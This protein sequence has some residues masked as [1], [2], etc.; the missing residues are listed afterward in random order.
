M[1]NGRNQTYSSHTGPL[2]NLV[3]ID[4][5]QYTNHIAGCLMILAYNHRAVKER[6]VSSLVLIERMV[7]SLVLIE[8]MVS[9]LATIEIKKKL[10]NKPITINSQSNKAKKS[11]INDTKQG[12]QINLE[13]FCTTSPFINYWYCVFLR[14]VLIFYFWVAFF[15]FKAFYLRTVFFPLLNR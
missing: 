5:Y 9:S 10:Q 6:M 8:R 13:A 15:F 7:S 14:E 3:D 11:S 12:H 2:Y 1:G 4:S